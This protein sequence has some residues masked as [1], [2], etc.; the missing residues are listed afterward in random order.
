MGQIRRRGGVW[1]IRY[2]D[3]NGRRREESARTDKWEKAR[4]LLKQREGDI[5]NGVP[6][7]R[8]SVGF[9]LMKPRRIC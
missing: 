1:W 5:A 9:A 3:G 6:F 7:R 2:Y 4:D 8:R